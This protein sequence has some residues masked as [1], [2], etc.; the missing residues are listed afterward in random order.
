MG[1]PWRIH[2][3]PLPPP[4]EL[5]LFWKLLEPNAPPRCPDARARREAAR[6]RPLPACSPR[7][8]SGGGEGRPAARPPSWLCGRP[9]A[10][11]A[12]AQR[13]GPERL[14]FMALCFSASGPPPRGGAHARRGRASFRLR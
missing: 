9:R 7:R 10:S 8:L 14:C 3:L 12:C 6:W 4:W 1:G 11:A 2:G 5:R 13:K